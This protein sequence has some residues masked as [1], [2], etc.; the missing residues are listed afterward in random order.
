MAIPVV[1][2]VY[3]AIIAAG[4]SLSSS[5]TL[6]DSGAPGTSPAVA[7][8]VMMGGDTLAGIL[9]PSGWTAASITF[10]VSIDGGVTWAELYDDGGNAV[11]ITSPP[12][13][14]FVM[15]NSHASYEWRG[16]NAIKVRSGTSGSP[17]TQSSGAT[18][19]LVGRPE[20]F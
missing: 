11:T 12:A 17:V 13:G 5:Y 15:L 18:V 8:G 19:M 14:A 3:G 7:G 10:Q 20:I 2:N 9:V 6:L 4:Q 1:L 16:I